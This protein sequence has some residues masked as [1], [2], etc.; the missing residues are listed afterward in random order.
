MDYVLTQIYCLIVLEA[1]SEMGFHGVKIEM[2]AESPSFW[3]IW[4]ESLPLHIQVL[5]GCLCSASHMASCV[6]VCVCLC[7]QFYLTLCY[8][9]EAV[10]W[11]LP[12][13]G[14]SRQEYWSRLPFP[15]LGDLRDSGIELVPPV[16][17]ALAGRF[18][19]TEPSHPSS[20][21]AT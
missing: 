11:L 9:K 3:R 16:C 15:P 5:R 7:T 17:P 21:P 8:P 6:C 20:K 1:V 14:F 13:R 4:E 19:T 12:D 2:S 18:F 10:A